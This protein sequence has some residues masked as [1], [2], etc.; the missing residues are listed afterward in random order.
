M[1]AKM[2][3]L[4]QDT[5][6]AGDNI[7]SNPRLKLNVEGVKPEAGALTYT[8]TLGDKL[9]GKVNT[10]LPKD[11]D[12]VMSKLNKAGDYVFT[13]YQ[14]GK[15]LDALNFTLDNKAP[16]NLKVSLGVDSGFKP[17]DGI[18]NDAT[19]KIEGLEGGATLQWRENAKADWKTVDAGA[20]QR[21]DKLATVDF[22]PL[23]A[24]GFSGQLEMRQIDAAGNTQNGA[25]KLKLTYDDT[26]P[27]IEEAITP[28]SDTILNGKAAVIRIV[29]SEALVGLDKNDFTVS[30]SSLASITG[31]KQVKL[32]DGQFAYDVTVAATKKGG[33]EVTVKFADTVAAQDLAGN[34]AD[35]SG[36]A[37]ELAGFWVGDGSLSV[38]LMKDS[39]VSNKDGVTNNGFIDIKG[40]RPGAEVEFRLKAQSQSE[41]SG[42]TWKTVSTS[43]ETAQGIQV[44][45]PDLYAQLGIDLDEAPLTGWRDTFE[46]RQG[47]ASDKVYPVSALTLTYDDYTDLFWGEPPQDELAHGQTTVLQFTSYEK[48]YDFDV[49]DLVISNTG[50]LSFVG[51]KEQAVKEFGETFWNYNV[52]VQ[53]TS[54]K[55]LEGEVEVSFAENASITDL[56]GNQVGLQQMDAYTLFIG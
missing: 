31:V 52:T 41:P 5:G 9:V 30:D 15:K 2:V 38:N 13:L 27:T 35:F 46:F 1:T 6:V 25:A 21:V 22:A 37:G 28:V 7:T 49:K 50:L 23:L 8:L 39:G 51:I 47:D 42:S 3:S 55:A 10:L 56:A 48:L 32:K 16:G 29:S 44:N 36:A 33:G 24:G 4:L 18:T 54:N 40:I 11:I 20:V 43:I 34:A 19:I 26:A 14:A 17:K 12:T 53:A 45:V